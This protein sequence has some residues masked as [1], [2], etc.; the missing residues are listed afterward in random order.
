MKQLM[1]V[2]LTQAERMDLASITKH[3]GMN[4]LV[5]R[6]V[7]VHVR[8]SLEQIHGVQPDDPDRTSKLDGIGT[9]SFGMKLLSEA[10]KSELKRNWDIL[11]KQEENEKG[12]PK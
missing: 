9:V 6:I 10:V 2:V 12:K 8:Q 5:D 7:D 3:P 4:V 11:A 1:P